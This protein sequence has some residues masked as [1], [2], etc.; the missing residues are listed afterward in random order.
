MVIEQGSFAHN[1]VIQHSTELNDAIQQL[2]KSEVIEQGIGTKNGA[3]EKKQSSV[4][5]GDLRE[6]MRWG[7]ET[8]Q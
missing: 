1:E 3:I 4:K 7:E 8:V 6:T 5:C 2:I